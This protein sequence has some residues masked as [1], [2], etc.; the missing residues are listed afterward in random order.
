[1]NNYRVAGVSVV[2]EPILKSW[3]FGNG[4]DECS[5]P[6]SPLV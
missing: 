1:M 5:V 6:L 3:N 4:I 2:S